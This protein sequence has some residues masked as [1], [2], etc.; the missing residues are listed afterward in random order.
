MSVLNGGSVSQQFY[1]LDHFSAV[2]A[3][4]DP[5]LL[6]DGEEL[7]SNFGDVTL[8]TGEECREQGAGTLYVTTR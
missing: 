2:T 3:S 8:A 5:E 4:G 1:G 6:Q 7:Y